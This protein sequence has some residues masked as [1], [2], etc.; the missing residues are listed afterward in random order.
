MTYLA[1]GLLWV[2]LSDRL[3]LGVEVQAR[4]GF[5]VAVAKGT[6]FVLISAGLG[7]WLVR[8]SGRDVA[9][10]DA[11]LQAVAG[12]TSDAVF[13]KNLDGCY[14]LFNEAAA[15]FVGRPVTEVLGRDDRD[16]F[17]PQSA[18][19]VMERDRR[20]MNA[21]VAEIGEEELTAAG[22]TRIYQAMKAPYRDAD[23]N[24]I[25]LV[26]ISRDVTDRVATE[27]RLKETQDRLLEAQRLARLGSWAWAPATGALWWSDAL[28]ELMG[29]GRTVFSPS[30]DAYRE[31]VHP[32]DRE[33]VT[34]RIE[35]LLAGAE[36]VCDEIRIVR[37]DGQ[38]VWVQTQAR[39][40][41]DANGCV[42][43][44]GIDQDITARK[45]A[46]EE[47]FA[48]RETL[49][50]VLD[51]IPQ[52][53]FWKAADLKYLGCNRPFAEDMGYANATE[54]VGKDDYQGAWASV[55]DSYRADDRRVIDTGEARLD[56]EEEL[57]GS[58][59]ARSWVRT[60]KQP[61][62]GLDGRVVGVL[63]TYEDVSA[64]KQ[65]EHVVRASEA[66]QTYLLHLSDALR[67]VAD[68]EGVLGVACRTLGERL[69]VDRAYY[70]QVDEAAGR[71]RIDQD[72]VRPDVSSLAGEYRLA[73][74]GW[75]G[76]VFRGGQP[77][78][79]ADVATA[80]QI[81]EADR[82]ALV[83]L[84]IG[85]FVAVPL[86]KG[87]SV[88]ALLCVTDMSPRAWTPAE[89]E[90]VWE[91][92]ER[93]WA[94]VEQARAA[95]NIRASEARFRTLIEFLPD[96]I[97]L[98]IGG[99]VAFCNPACVRLFGADDQ[100]QL[101]GKTP[102][103]LLSPKYHD[104]IRQRI[105][106][107]QATK[108]PVPGVEEE[109]VRLDGRTVPV[110]VTALPITDDGDEALLVVL[111]DLTEQKRLA[112]QLRHQELLLREASELAHVGG[113]G[114][115]PIT[116]EA[117]WTAEVARIHDLDTVAPGVGPGIDFYV[118]EDRPQLD[119]A[120][121]A[122]I[123]LGIPYD[124]EL[125]IISARG[126]R[127]WVRTICRPI[128][129]HQKVVRVRGSLQE[130]TERKR[131]EAEI[132]QLNADLEQR[133][134]D[135]TAELEASN[136]ELES[137]S[138]SVSHDLRAPLRAING[139][140]QIVLDEYAPQ[141]PA[142]AR[143]YLDDVR[144]NARRMGTLVDDLLA[145]SRLGRQPVKR[146]PVDVKQMVESCLREVVLSTDGRATE[147]C[148]GDLPACEADP[149]LLRQVWLNLLSNAVKYSGR[150][151]SAVIEVGAACDPF[152]VTYYVRDNGV[153]FDMAYA[154]KLF[155]VFQRLHRAEDYE[156][157]GIG[158]AL[159]QRI[160]HRHGGRIW[161]EAVPDV[162]AT[163]SFTLGNAP[164]TPLPEA[165]NG[166]GGVC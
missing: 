160:V 88:V 15:R 127:K 21:G 147:A 32:A 73:D 16:L 25:G 157:T 154:H 112:M 69:G 133:V 56:Y 150:K 87:N 72:F 148:V 71:I 61:L 135:R 38:T 34:R 149:A 101:L 52:R 37:P 131:I 19:R 161:A 164:R 89:V 10:T 141:L 59:G 39:T 82:P 117:D 132:R 98:N 36:S 33:I 94:A 165:P 70:C 1:F 125:Q 22:V 105:A 121:R 126:V 152:G 156:G 118:P 95:T 54:V 11:L 129:D 8:R 116:G 99:R 48:S 128:V 102:F 91:T 86:V 31:L 114:F 146:Q 137:F 41:R 80:A 45:K 63:G 143:E 79:V 23:G 103:E 78:A 120:L 62:R 155:G 106:I 43:V 47:L 58:G 68:P 158:L 30:A 46:E 151:N 109:V 142:E 44:D 60:S 7:Y 77:A 104:L 96:A 9:R 162:G 24:V 27:R 6:T 115:D 42:L 153:G 76:P 138:Y 85:A 57:I 74:F 51:G 123:E 53:V 64:R 139:F 18:S 145:F 66:R 97:Y 122:A 12:S 144:A 140:T 40:T 13:V 35:S 65:A 134:R 107:L 90:L 111:H 92:A 119:A 113:W 110:F 14:L 4:T 55:A 81:P 130:I 28:Y 29:V 3:V 5:W 108:Q 75:V 100:S 124:L 93:T 50:A 20:I 49:R 84:R 26:G 67:P 83:A 136:R 159:V 163:F 166:E 2:W 17:D